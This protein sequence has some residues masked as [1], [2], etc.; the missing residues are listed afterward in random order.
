[1]EELAWDPLKFTLENKN[2]NVS[3]YIYKHKICIKRERF[4]FDLNDK[5]KSF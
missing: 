1:M 3:C 4:N 2:E 5:R